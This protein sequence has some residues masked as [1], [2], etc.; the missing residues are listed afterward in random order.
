MPIDAFNADYWTAVAAIAPVFALANTVT[1]VSVGRHLP[2]TQG[3]RATARTAGSE[4]AR[5]INIYGWPRRRMVA[6]FNYV[7]QAIATAAAHCSPWRT[8]ANCS[9]RRWWPD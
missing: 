5:P 2:R 9:G 8:V 1:M 3:R 6:L 4:E 7:L